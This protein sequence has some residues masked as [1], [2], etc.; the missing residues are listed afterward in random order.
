MRSNRKDTAPRKETGFTLIELLVVIAIIAILIGLLV[1]AVQ[2]VR[3]AAAR[4]T[5]ED[6]LMT[7]LIPAAIAYHNQK[8]TFPGSLQ[9]LEALI[10]L[11]LA[12]GHDGAG[13]TYYVSSA[14]G[15]VWKVGVEPDCP[16]ETG[17]ESVVLELSLQRDG[18]FVSRLTRYPT[19]GADK[20]REDMIGGISADGAQTIMALLKLHPGAASEAGEFVQA[21]ATLDQV[22]ALLD[23]D[24]NGRI[25]LLEHYDYPGAFAQRF[26]G[27]D[28]EL[29]VPLRAFLNNVS[30][31]MKLDVLSAE[32]ARKVEVGVGSLRSMDSGKTWISLDQMCR[33]TQLYVTD[34]KVANQL[35]QNLKAAE[36]AIER[37]DRRA[38]DKFFSAYRAGLE[39]EVNRTLTRKNATTLANVFTVWLTLG[40]F[41]V[42]DD[43]TT[44]VKRR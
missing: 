3:A 43:P 35:C 12:S 40:F 34:E 32:A 4:M 41:E 27:V 25:S 20:G 30:Q 13:N 1:P 7:I 17:S 44:R 8:G 2:K 6:N 29:E 22:L 33:L 42:A 21:P 14:S 5:A 16:G 23:K 15:G 11:E 18:E 10:G 37:G 39:E 28:E 38:R 26:D 24:H 9:D 31:R 36:A 19:P